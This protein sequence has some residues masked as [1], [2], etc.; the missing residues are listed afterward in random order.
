MFGFGGVG[1]DID[2]CRAVL[3]PQ[4]AQ[5]LP[6]G[7]QRRQPLGVF[8]DA[9]GDG[10]DVVRDVVEIGLHRSQTIGE[11]PIRGAVAQG[12]ERGRDG[13]ERRAVVA[14]ERGARQCAGF[15]MGQR[16][17]QLALVA[18]E[19]LVFVGVGEGRA[20]QLVD[21]E[22]VEIDLARPRAFVAAERR[23]RGVDRR[24]LRAGSFEGRRVDRTEAIERGA[25]RCGR[26]ERLVRVLAVDV[27]ERQAELGQRCHRREAP[28]E[29][30]A[31]TTV[32]RHDAA[33][34]HLV[35]GREHESTFDDRLGAAGAHHR[36][37]GPAAEQQPDRFD[38]HR[39]ARARLARDRG[40]AGPEHE[41]EIGD[42]S[43]VGDGQFGEHGNV[44]EGSAV[45]EAELRFEH[46]MEV[47]WPERDQPRDPR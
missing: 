41:R 28:V 18:L 20:L 37:V 2:E 40:E 22:P 24:Q 10:P 23:E 42:D 7:P 34:D 47:A 25:L 15:A 16:V 8:F 21:L 43:E 9:L 27:D 32:A 4:V 36:A 6:A 19:S 1:D 45:V 11:R 33:H 3:A 31:G 38:D 46:G 39:L 26:H 29:I 35:V 30:G 14:A 13:V 5:Q 17:G 44:L 12:T